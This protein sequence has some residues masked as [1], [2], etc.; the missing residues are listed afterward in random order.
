MGGQAGVSALP[1]VPMLGQGR[2]KWCFKVKDLV[3]DYRQLTV[4]C[5]TQLLY[6]SHES[7]K[8]PSVGGSSPYPK[9]NLSKTL[10]CQGTNLP[11][12][13]ARPCSASSTLTPCGF[14]ESMDVGLAYL[15]QGNPQ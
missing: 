9:L 3:R 11:V 1:V 10:R 2:G 4:C 7:R 13:P 6:K 15:C 12:A 8:G 5:S 14:I